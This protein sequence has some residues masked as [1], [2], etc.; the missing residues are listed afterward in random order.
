MQA[1]LRSMN[2]PIFLARIRYVD[3]KKTLEVHTTR[4]ARSRVAQAVRGALAGQELAT[5]V[6]VH[7]HGK[8]FRP[9][10]LES[11]SKQFGSGSILYDPTGA[12]ERMEAYIACAQAVRSASGNQIAGIYMEPRHGGLYIIPSIVGIG[13]AAYSG[14]LKVVEEISVA[15]GR[16]AARVGAL[17]FPVVAMVEP[18]SGYRLVPV[19]AMSAR[20]TAVRG[21]VPSFAARFGILLAALGLAAGT[22]AAHA[23]HPSAEAKAVSDEGFRA[24][25]SV[26]EPSASL[27]ETGDAV[28]EF[29]PSVPGLVRLIETPGL[30]KLSHGETLERSA[31]P[32]LAPAAI[33]FV[34]FEDGAANGAGLE[35]MLRDTLGA[36]MAGAISA[37]A[38]A[39]Q[40]ETSAIQLAQQLGS[41]GSGY[42]GSLGGDTLN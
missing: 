14:V 12:F 35:S 11:L 13:T 15:I 2:L 17:S 20:E 24:L 10:S 28:M 31:A 30:V 9:R 1:L 39:L 41:G 4:E 42:G 38:I 36:R 33:A 26:Y 25:S 3:G 37:A 21:L 18:P 8:F 19:D 27:F 6:V 5:E 16:H 32:R 40:G 29:A 34:S 22:G 7:G 23:Y